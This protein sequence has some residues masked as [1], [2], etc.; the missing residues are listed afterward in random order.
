[1]YWHLLQLDF[2]KK[3][4]PTIFH[5]Y[6]IEVRQRLISREAFIY[7]TAVDEISNSE[8]VFSDNQPGNIPGNI[9]SLSNSSENVIGFFEVS[10]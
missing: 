3:K 7:Y 10:K 9:K 2:S 1:M 8:N 5:R 4:N 6:S